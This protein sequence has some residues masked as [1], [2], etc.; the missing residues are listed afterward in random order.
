[1]TA[2]RLTASFAMAALALVAFAGC[3]NKEAEKAEEARLAAVKEL[4]EA[5][6]QLT[7]VKEELVAT[8][9][10]LSKAQE[11]LATAVTDKA[12]L[13]AKLKEAKDAATT[14]EEELKTATAAGGELDS[15]KAQL[16]QVQQQLTDALKTQADLKAQALAAEVRAKKAEASLKT[17]LDAAAQAPATPEMPTEDAPYEGAIDDSVV[18][19]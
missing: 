5:K 6:A 12:D 4:D 10:T 17:A 11:D 8:E 18:I 2:A 9:A 15:V 13:E 3:S 19:E 14:L 1:M 7:S 16:A